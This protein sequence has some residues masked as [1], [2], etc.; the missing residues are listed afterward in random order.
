LIALVI[1]VDGQPVITVDGRAYTPAQLAH[2][3]T[4]AERPAPATDQS[5]PLPLLLGVAATATLLG[6]SDDEVYEMLDAGDL[7][8]ARRGRRRLVVVQSIYRWIEQA[9]GNRG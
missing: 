9:S 6:L 7:Q 2:A 4:V 1:G 5:G 3:L 8:E